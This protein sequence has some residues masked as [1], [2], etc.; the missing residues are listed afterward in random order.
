MPRSSA[1]SPRYIKSRIQTSTIGFGLEVRKSLLLDAGNGLFATKP[2]IKNEYITEYDGDIIDAARAKMLQSRGKATHIRSLEPQH[3]AIDGLKKPS[4]AHNRGGASFANDGLCVANKNATFTKAIEVPGSQVPDRRT[5]P[6]NSKR[7]FI[8]AARNISPGEEILVSYGRDYW[9]TQFQTAPSRSHCRK[10]KANSRSALNRKSPP[11]II[12]EPD[13]YE[14]LDNWQPRR[15]SGSREKMIKDSDPLDDIVDNQPR[16]TIPNARKR[17]PLSPRTKQP[18]QKKPRQSSQRPWGGS[19]RVT[20]CME[21]CLATNTPSRSRIFKADLDDDPD[22]SE[23]DEG[24]S[25]ERKQSQPKQSISVQV[26]KTQPLAKPV[27]AI[28]DPEATESEEDVPKRETGPSPNQAGLAKARRQ[29]RPTKTKVEQCIPKS[30]LVDVMNHVLTGDFPGLIEEYEEF[31]RANPEAPESKVNKKI[32]DLESSS[33]KLVIDQLRRVINT[34]TEWNEIE[35]KVRVQCPQVTVTHDDVIKVMK[36]LII[37]V[38]GF[39]TAAI[40]SGE[41]EFNGELYFDKFDDEEDLGSTKM[42]A[43]ERKERKKLYG[44][45]IAELTTIS[46]KRNK[47]S[48]GKLS[49]RL[50]DIAGEN[51]N[52]VQPDRVSNIQQQVQSNAPDAAA[53]IFLPVVRRKQR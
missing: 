7:I 5:G 41:T 13:G 42:T 44:M 8:R 36:K 17:A 46:E 18:R 50:S 2:F 31:I 53:P 30:T 34:P 6:A 25:Q 33:F 4:D 24:T 32:D 12:N 3:S 38:K 26:E 35:R 1:K 28:E 14:D 29:P 10:P 49:K 47:I 40:K 23:I 21:T 19:D 20:K 51:V 27:E 43:E 11:A 45:S 22:A 9:K 39:L 52:L 16:I 48:I 15:K 37:Q